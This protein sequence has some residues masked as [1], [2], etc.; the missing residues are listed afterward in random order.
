MFLHKI[1]PYTNLP[2][3]IRF[4]RNMYQ[5][6][7][8]KELIL[9]GTVTDSTWP[10]LFNLWMHFTFFIIVPRLPPLVCDWIAPT[11]SACTATLFQFWLYCEQKYHGDPQQPELKADVSLKQFRNKA[12]M[13]LHVDVFM[14]L[15]FPEH[16]DVSSSSSFSH[17]YPLLRSRSSHCQLHDNIWSSDTSASFQSLP[18]RKSGGF[19]YQPFSGTRISNLP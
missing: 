19:Y 16:N 9:K 18:K 12:Q 7:L 2:T 17:L 1:A 3:T 6:I 13:N 4:P 11:G 15:E 14:V 10:L 5:D 8:E